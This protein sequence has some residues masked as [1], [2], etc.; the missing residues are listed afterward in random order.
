MRVLE[1]YIG[2]ILQKH[3]DS[4]GVAPLGLQ[5]QTRSVHLG[6]LNP[7]ESF[8]VHIVLSVNSYKGA[9]NL[10]RRRGYGSCRQAM[11][12]FYEEGV[13]LLAQI[14]LIPAELGNLIVDVTS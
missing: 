13:S 12:L 11:N 14:R 1:V 9:G 7:K 4:R 6:G 2:S 3:C 5:H 10:S 8:E